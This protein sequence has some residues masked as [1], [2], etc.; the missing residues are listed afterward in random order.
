MKV[1]GSSKTYQMYDKAYY[2]N[3]L[4]TLLGVSFMWE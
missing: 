1:A 4:I 2:H 3:I